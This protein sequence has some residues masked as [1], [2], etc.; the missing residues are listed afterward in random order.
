MFERQNLLNHVAKHI[1]ELPADHTIRVGIDGVDG[2]GK[3][4]FANELTHVLAGT[5]RPIIQAS[6]DSFH[7]P[8]VVRYRLG[9]TSPEGYFRDSYNYP[10]L[11]EVLLDPLSPNG[12]GQYRTA[13]F[14]HKLNSPVAM[15]ARQAMPNS[16]LIFDGIFLHRPELRMVWDF[17]IFL[18]VD[19]D[20]SIP[21][22]AQRGGGSPDPQAPENYRYM[23]GQK[24]Y[25]R[26]CHPQK[27]ATLV[28]NN[29]DLAAPYIT[30]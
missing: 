11:K 13:I 29:E 18:Q 24:L 30:A 2:S 7:N 8:K 14:D 20:V 25:L 10:Q 16:I 3:T 19:F 9:Q 22:M 4:F 23:E 12:S 15:P 6:V 17:S 5:K 1:L 26:E 28:I 27:Y 21:R